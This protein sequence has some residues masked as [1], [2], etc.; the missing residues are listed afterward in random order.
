MTIMTKRWLPAAGIA[1][2]LC[3]VGAGL[4]TAKYIHNRPATSASAGATDNSGSAAQPDR[5]DVPQLTVPAGTAIRVQLDQSLDSSRN[6]AGDV[7]DA[8]TV[9]PVLIDNRLAIPENT[10]VRGEVAYA[11]PSGHFSHPG[12]LEI[13][14][15][16]VELDGNWLDIATRENARKGGSHTKNNAGWIGGG[17]GG[18]M[19]I[20]A[21]AAG[22]KGA[23]IGGPIGAGAGTAV[24]FFTGKRNV[25]LSAESQLV[26]H[27]AQPISVTPQG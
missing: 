19:L 13:S 15:K 8:H 18:G 16:Q 27:L 25:H 10:P 22:G 9:E 23:L 2:I 5:P 24:A 12:S 7:F 6:R 17:A 1:A 11:R 21:L 4:A 14:L 20:G 3:L 26:F